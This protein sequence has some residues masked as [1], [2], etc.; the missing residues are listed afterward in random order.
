MV[1]VAKMTVAERIGHAVGHCL[2]LIIR[3]ETTVLRRLISKGVPCFLAS[4]LKWAVRLTLIFG[5]LYF[6]LV[7]ALIIT[8]IVLYLVGGNS[9][10]NVDEE[11][12]WQYIQDYMEKERKAQ[13]PEWQD[14]PLGW[15]RYS[16]DDIA[17]DIH[18][19]GD[20]ERWFD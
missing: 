11:E 5:L 17:H 2:K 13:E 14:E 6:A 3:L 10:G 7:P 4:V 19:E 15:G 12:D 20:P 1:N 16:H 18:Y 8:P 9:S